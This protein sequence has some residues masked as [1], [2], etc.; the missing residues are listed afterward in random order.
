MNYQRTTV[1]DAKAFGIPAAI[2]I[3]PDD[4]RF[5]RYLNEAIARLAYTG[6]WVGAIQRIRICLTG[7]C[8]ICPRDVINLDGV[9]SG[10]EIINVRNQWY[11]YLGPELNPLCACDC[12]VNLINRDFTPFPKPFTG[13]DRICIHNDPCESGTTVLLR[14]TDQNGKPVR[15]QWPAGSGRW[16]HGER[17]VLTSEPFTC[18]STTFSTLNGI[19]K[20]ETTR[21]IQLF[22]EQD[23][24]NPDLLL[25]EYGAT[26]T[27]P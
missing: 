21:S 10:C 19:Q 1:A 3:P 13:P 9:I 18:S 20:D 5:I 22:R 17:I 25:A 23:N 8:I 12:S 4:P 15:G 14:G 6:P 16:E 7:S 26:E 2:G 24:G 27:R 11:E